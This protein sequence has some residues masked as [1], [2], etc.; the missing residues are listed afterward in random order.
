VALAG[1]PA[2]A[3][4]L[5]EVKT[6]VDGALAIAPDFAESHVSLALF[7]YM[8][9]REY[10]QA[11][12]A[13]QRALELSRITRMHESI[14]ATS[15]G[16]WAVGTLAG[17]DGQ[18]RRTG[19]SGRHIPANI[20]ASY[21]NLRQWNDAKRAA[22]RSLTLHPHN[23]V[24]LRNLFLSCVNGDGRTDAARRVIGSCRPA[25]PSRQTRSRERLDI[26]EDFSY[27]QVLERDFAGALQHAK[28]K[29]EIRGTCLATCARVAIRVLAGDAA[30]EKA[31]SE[32]AAH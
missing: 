4:E 19:P 12:P 31:E 15:I 2:N 29:N 28:N 8:G 7:H 24:G 14:P 32:E 5:E 25:S 30:G 11:L 26:I 6:L 22:S 9:H 18:G 17:R 1:D 16:G 21:V 27:L 10:E 23:Q 3:V 13:F 20:A